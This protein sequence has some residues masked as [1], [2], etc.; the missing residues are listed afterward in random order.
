MSYSA[1][2]NLEDNGDSSSAWDA[3]RKNTKISAK[4]CIV[5][6]EAKR[7]ETWF[8]EECSKFVDRRKQAKLRWLQDPCIGN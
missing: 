7:H 3:V 5:H 6:C 8:D 2:E 4:E 1:L